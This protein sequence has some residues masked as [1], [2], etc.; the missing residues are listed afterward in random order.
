MT[1]SF[2]TALSPLAL[3]QKNY[4]AD[5]APHPLK[6][7]SIKEKLGGSI[8]LNLVFVNEK[9]Q[10]PCFKKIFWIRACVNEYCLLQLPKPL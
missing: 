7:I 1:I 9:N 2:V 6:N 8:D 3:S 4:R 5:E 10:K